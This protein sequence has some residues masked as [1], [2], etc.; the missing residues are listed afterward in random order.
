MS[1]CRKL[2]LLRML[3]AM[4]VLQDLS[5]AAARGRICEN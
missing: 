5:D 2:H 3:T 4:A 1:V